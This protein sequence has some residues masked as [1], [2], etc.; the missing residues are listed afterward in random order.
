M[1]AWEGW[2]GEGVMCGRL[3]SHPGG[4]TILSRLKD[5]MLSISQSWDKEK[6][7]IPN[8]IGIHDLPDTDRALTTELG[9][10]SW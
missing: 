3:V 4:V 1:I 7:W 5:E 10:D 6:I 9:R 8:G 2:V